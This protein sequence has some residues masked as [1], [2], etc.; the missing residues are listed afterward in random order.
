MAAAG[1]GRH[2]SAGAFSGI[3]A[4]SI[5]TPAE[6]TKV[7][8]QLD[9][10]RTPQYRSSLHCLVQRVRTLG[11]Q[12][13]AYLGTHIM[14]WREIVGYALYFGVY[15]ACR[16]A[17]VPLWEADAAK[18]R[19]MMLSV[20]VEGDPAWAQLLA[21]GM[22][23]AV[24]WAV[25]FPLDAVKTLIQSGGG[26]LGILQAARQ[27]QATRGWQGLFSGFQVCMLRG[28]IANAVTFWGYET[29]VSMINSAR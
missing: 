7:V 29:C 26:S 24:S 5:L 11:V 16:A 23:G 2:L 18:A 13:G 15:Q 19:A 21:G 17:V 25:I 20:D 12:Q 14:L 3:L 8:M 1:I 10:G 27:L 9:R 22:A 6:L 28:F 4:T